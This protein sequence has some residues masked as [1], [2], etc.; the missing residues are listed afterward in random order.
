MQDVTTSGSLKTT[1]RS[2][3]PEATQNHSD[4]LFAEA[5][6][7]HDCLE[8]GAF[9]DLEQFDDA[10]RKDHE[11]LLVS[12]QFQQCLRDLFRFILLEFLYEFCT[13]M[14]NEWGDGKSDGK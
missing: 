13:E 5:L 11:T 1:K 12:C 4:V 14:R 8:T 6:A 3:Y 10:L 2:S 9:L 7:F